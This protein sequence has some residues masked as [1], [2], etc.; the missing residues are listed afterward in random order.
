MAA[1]NAAKGKRSG[2]NIRDA[3][4]KLHVIMQD[5]TAKLDGEAAAE[6]LRHLPNTR[7]FAWVFDVRWSGQRPFQAVLNTA[8]AA[9]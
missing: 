7:R 6:G 4:A 2:L 3:Y 1:P 8:C 5:G 9:L